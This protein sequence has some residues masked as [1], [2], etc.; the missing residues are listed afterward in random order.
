MT[1]SCTPTS[2]LPC[3]KPGASRTVGANTNG[4]GVDRGFDQPLWDGAAFDGKTL[5]VHA[6]Q[7]LGDTTQ[8]VRY[9]RFVK[10][11]SGT[12]LLEC[13]PVQVALFGGLEGADAIVPYGEPLPAFDRHYPLLGLPRR[14]GTTLETVPAAKCLIFPSPRAAGPGASRQPRASC[15]WG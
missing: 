12:V 1:R 7:G 2:P 15:G 8:F 5:P 10:H 9:L 14:L 11:R 13:Q 6:E 3:L 4:K